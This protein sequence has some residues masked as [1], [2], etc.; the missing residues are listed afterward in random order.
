MIATSGAPPSTAAITE[1]VAAK[2]PCKS[3]PINACTTIG[4]EEMKIRSASMPCLSKAPVSLAIHRPVPA[5]PTVEYPRV[6]FLRSAAA[7]P[8]HNQSMVVT[9]ATPVK[10][11]SRSH[12]QRGEASSDCSLV[13]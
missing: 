4:P 1:L 11:S 8:P 7:A 13:R 10:K 5:G 9:T 12:G 6:N 2:P 3:P